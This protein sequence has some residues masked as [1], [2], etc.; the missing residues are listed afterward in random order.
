MEHHSVIIKNEIMP[1]TTWMQLEILILSEVSQKENDKYHNI[2]YMWNLKYSTN[3]TICE[4][5]T[6]SQTCRTELWLPRDGAKERNGLGVG[7]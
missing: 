3:E 5:E 2:T 6:D 7:G 4:T 1:F